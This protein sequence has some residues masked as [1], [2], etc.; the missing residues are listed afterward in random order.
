MLAI[1]V[2]EIFIRLNFLYAHFPI[3]KLSAD[4]LFPIMCK[5]VHVD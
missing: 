4:Q 1:M 5:A 2:R 3:D